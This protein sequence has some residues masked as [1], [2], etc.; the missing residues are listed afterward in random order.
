MQYDIV[1]TVVFWAA[2]LFVPPVI[3]VHHKAP[4]GS[5]FYALSQWFWLPVLATTL[6]LLAGHL[7]YGGHARWALPLTWGLA[8]LACTPLLALDSL[9][10][11]R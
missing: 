5:K 6:G 3:F 2:V 11:S 1:I 10:K 4:W 9:Q 7:I 8:A